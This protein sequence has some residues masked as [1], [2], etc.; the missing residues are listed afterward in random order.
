MIR[1]PPRSTRTDTLFPY[2]TLF[3]SVEPRECVGMTIR[4]KRI[5]RVSVSADDRKLMSNK[6]LGFNEAEAEHAAIARASAR[7]LFAETGC[8]DKTLAALVHG[9]PREQVVR[10]FQQYLKDRKSTRLNSSH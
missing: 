1:R 5:S 4:R 8:S 9:L 2:T 10:F 6:A 3:R 7:A